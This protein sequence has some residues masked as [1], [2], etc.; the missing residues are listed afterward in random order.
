M[1]IRG[2][3][4]EAWLKRWRMGCCPVHGGGFVD[5]VNAEL[6]APALAQRCHIDDCDVRTVR[7]PGPDAQHASFGW[8][9][10]PEPI[11]LLLVKAADISADDAKPGARGRL[12]R[13]DYALEL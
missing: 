13:V 8:R 1:S 7:W 5:D 10:G 11:R 6:H 3:H 9:A 4:N 12:V 2:Q